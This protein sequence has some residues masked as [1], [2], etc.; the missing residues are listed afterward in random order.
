VYFLLQESNY[1]HIE[2]MHTVLPKISKKKIAWNK[3]YHNTVLLLHLEKVGISESLKVA[4]S[5]R[6]NIIEVLFH[7][8]TEPRVEGCLLQECSQR[9]YSY[10]KV[11]NVGRRECQ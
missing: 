8:T 7:I 6:R 9:K 11:R 4:V 1:L 5:C 10:D 2:N 3:Q